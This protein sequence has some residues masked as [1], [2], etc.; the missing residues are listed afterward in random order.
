MVRVVALLLL[1]PALAS[2]DESAAR[3]GKYSCLVQEAYP[4]VGFA[5]SYVGERLEYDADEGVLEL[6]QKIELVDGTS[7]W[8]PPVSISSRLFV[9]T[10]PSVEGILHAVQFD[11]SSEDAFRPYVAWLKIDAPNDNFMSNFMYFSTGI[12]GLV[13]GACTHL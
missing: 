10:E 13:T 8:L 3:L 12:E 7:S 6:A 11:K 9:E 4:N 2:P 1:F 5:K